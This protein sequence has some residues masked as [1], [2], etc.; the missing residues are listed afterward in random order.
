[1]SNQ[2]MPKSWPT[3]VHML[4]AAAKASPNQLALVHG[5]EALTYQE[6]AACVSGLARL[7]NVE[8]IGKN[9]R[10]ALVMKNSLDIA[11]ATFAVQ[12]AGAQ[13]VPL[14]PLYTAAELKPV[15]E[16]AEVKGII[17]DGAC[18]Q[19]I[20]NSLP[21]LEETLCLAVTEEQRLTQWKN[22]H[23]LVE[24]LPLPASDGLSTLQY[25]GGTTGVPKGV[26][27]SHRAISMNIS[28]REALLPT[29]SSEER[30]LV[31]TPLFHIYAVSMGLYLSV[32][33]QS[34]MYIMDRY[35]PKDTLENIQKY[36]I[37]LLSASPTIYISLMSYDHFSDYDLSSLRISY[38]GSAALSEE[39]LRQW[40]SLTGCIVCE[41]YGQTEAGPILTYNPSY[42]NRKIGSVGM[43]VPDTEINIVDLETGSK[44]LGVGEQGEIRARGW[45][46]MNGYRGMPVETNDSL[47]NGWLYTGDIGYLDSDGY[48]YICDR[49]KEMVIVS[50]FNVYPREIEEALF[51]HPDIIEAAVIGLDDSYRGEKLV[52][53]VKSK[54]SSLNQESILLFLEKILIKY[55]LPSSVIFLD[56]I[57]KTSIGKIDKNKLKNEKGGMYE[58]Q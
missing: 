56:V 18:A 22:D 31:I 29:N 5:E 15:F 20:K 10:V 40:E 30:I 1:M 39:T 41:G 43:A 28:Q 13:V 6:Y 51:T 50:G 37:T 54:N 7:L 35:H 17:F 4:D 49:K 47:R 45:Q 2:K 19:V 46:I 42:M 33:C 36:K 3:V 34:A 8:G 58:L 21:R 44:V 57:P 55:K 52:A 48:L 11:I 23:Y 24:L 26:D 12:A 25:T 38:S 14:N 53:F 32:Y 9:D 16:N 27:L